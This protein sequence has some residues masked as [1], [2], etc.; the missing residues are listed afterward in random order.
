VTRSPGGVCDLVDAGVEADDRTE[1]RREKR[2]EAVSG[3]GQST[4][5]TAPGGE[6]QGIDIDLPNLDIDPP[7]SRSTL[8]RWTLTFGA[9]ISTFRASISTFRG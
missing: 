4:S 2:W 6:V 3:C 9:S 1:E 5:P 8:G 7:T